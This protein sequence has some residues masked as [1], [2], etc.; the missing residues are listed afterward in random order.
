MSLGLSSLFVPPSE[1]DARAH[2]AESLAGSFGSWDD[3]SRGDEL[4]R[5]L[6][7]LRKEV[8]GLHEEVRLAKSLLATSWVDLTSAPSPLRLQL[9]S[10]QASTSRVVSSS[11]ARTSSSLESA[12][13]LSFE[14]YELSD[15]LTSLQ[16]RADE[17]LPTDESWSVGPASKVTLRERLGELLRQLDEASLG[18]EYLLVL[19]ELLR[20]QCVDICSS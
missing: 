10:S 3:L 18:R 20:L 5:R 1:A 2:A 4:A 17:P 9:A 11:L 16:E 12:Q 8:D 7:Q 15:L 19:E 6:D 13:T 14:R